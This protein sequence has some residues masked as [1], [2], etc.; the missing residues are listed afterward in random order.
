MTKDRQE[1]QRELPHAMIYT[2]KYVTGVLVDYCNCKEN[3]PTLPTQKKKEE[4]NERGKDGG[5]KEGRGGRRR[6]ERE[7]G[8]GGEEKGS[9]YLTVEFKSWASSR[10]CTHGKY[11][12]SVLD[13]G[14]LFPVFSFMSSLPFYM[15][16]LC[17]SF[18]QKHPSTCSSATHGLK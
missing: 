13:K 14:K 11:S 3:K 15:Y 6:E 1:S 18:A 2:R 5:G 10:L 9:E 17:P 4:R 8:R 7:E 16:L 12:L